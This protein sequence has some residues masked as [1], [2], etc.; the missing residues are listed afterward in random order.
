MLVAFGDWSFQEENECDPS[1]KY[2]IKKK[3]IEVYIVAFGHM[4]EAK[5]YSVTLGWSR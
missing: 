4:R 2:F 3:K 1:Y 5:D